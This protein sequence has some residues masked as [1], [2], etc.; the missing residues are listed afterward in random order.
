MFIW[1]PFLLSKGFIVELYHFLCPNEP[2]WT[3]ACRGAWGL[4]TGGRAGMQSRNA[5]K[6]RRWI[7]TMISCIYRR[8]RWRFSCWSHGTSCS[9]WR[10]GSHL[11]PE[12]RRARLH[13]HSES[14]RISWR[15]YLASAVIYEGAAACQR[16]HL[17]GGRYEYQDRKDAGQARNRDGDIWIAAA[18]R[19]EAGRMK[20]DVN[21]E[22]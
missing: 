20:I 14:G 15:V 7:C 10:S 22:K 13:R 4:R 1:T 8:H 9:F 11:I 18:P 17:S 6:R 21:T 3:P 19:G 5:R 12:L 2:L 16:T